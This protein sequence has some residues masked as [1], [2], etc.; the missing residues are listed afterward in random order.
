MINML[1]QEIL[2]RTAGHLAAFNHERPLH[3]LSMDQILVK[4]HQALVQCQELGDHK[5]KLTGQVV[6][7]L[8]TKTRQL[9]LDPISNGIYIIRS[10]Y[11]ID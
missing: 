10:F 4:L 7:M 11:C 8:S 1:K 6:E 2:L 9:G 3:S 5:V